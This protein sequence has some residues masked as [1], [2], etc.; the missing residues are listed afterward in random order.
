MNKRLH[1]LGLGVAL[2]LA[3]CLDDIEDP[4]KLLGTCVVPAQPR[5]TCEERV[6]EKSCV[7]RPLGAFYVG[8][9]CADLQGSSPVGAK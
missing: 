7:E 5:P 8:R 2:A 3:G 1:P 6:T 9:T 4:D